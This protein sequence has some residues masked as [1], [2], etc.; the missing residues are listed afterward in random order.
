MSWS[1]IGLVFGL[2]FGMVERRWVGGIK[3]VDLGREIIDG[4]TGGWAPLSF[5]FLVWDLSLAVGN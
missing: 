4:L 1:V 3:Y 5:F 2:V